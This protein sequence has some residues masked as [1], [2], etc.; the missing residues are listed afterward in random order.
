[1]VHKPRLVL[2]VLLPLLAFVAA[3]ASAVFIR[4]EMDVVEAEPL[5]DSEYFLDLL[6]FAPPL[7]WDWEW[8]LALSSRPAAAYRVNGASLDCCELLL[9]QHASARRRLTDW[10]DFRY[11][12]E[13]RDDKDLQELHQWLRFEAGPW[14]GVSLGAFGEPTFAKQDADIG[15]L[16]RYRPLAG[17][18]V[19]GS[20]NA[21]DW[22]LNSRGTTGERYERRPYTYEAGLEAWTPAGR[23]RPRVEVD[24]P[25]IRFDP[26]LGRR[27]HYRR[28]TAALV[29]DLPPSSPGRPGFRL[30]YRHEHKDEGL[31]LEPDPARSSLDAARRLHEARAAALLP[32]GPRATLEAGAGA[33]WRSAR[34]AAPGAS[35]PGARF[36]RWEFQPYARWRNRLSARTVGEVA[37][38]LSAGELREERLGAPARWARLVEA[39]LGLGLDFLFAGPS[40]IGLYTNWDLDDAA[41]HVWDGGNVR[42]QLLF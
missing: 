31:R 28:T 40:R 17:L 23:L 39:K 26:A 33:L 6:A 27:Y 15:W 5:F 35:A 25:L 11:D 18:S 22:N 20:R 21:V 1:M 4:D 19:Y 29:W 34:S 37:T 13:Q 38:F 32:A 9:D 10:L 42:A 3:P 41:R 30:R 24:A 14:R 2:R 16:L 8:E 12:L 7:E 36:L